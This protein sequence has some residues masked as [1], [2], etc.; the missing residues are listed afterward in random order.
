MHGLFS[1]I[2]NLSENHSIEQ[3]KNNSR[4]L[5]EVNMFRNSSIATADFFWFFFFFII[6]LFVFTEM[7]YRQMSFGN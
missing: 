4:K 1:F 2:K 3:E 6:G 7:R 5:V